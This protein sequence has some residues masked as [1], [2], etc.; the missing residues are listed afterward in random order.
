MKRKITTSPAIEH[1]FRIHIEKQVYV[2][3]HIATFNRFLVPT[4]NMTSL[5]FRFTEQVVKFNTRHLRV[6]E[7]IKVLE[8]NAD[9]KA[10]ASST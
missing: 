1:E 10:A 4:E 3:I 6:H 2:K 5:S 7:L 9:F 8:V